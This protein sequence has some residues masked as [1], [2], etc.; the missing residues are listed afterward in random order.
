MDGSPLCHLVGQAGSA[1]CRCRQGPHH[2]GA[3]AQGDKLRKMARHLQALL[4]DRARAHRRG[5]GRAPRPVGDVRDLKGSLWDASSLNQPL[6]SD[7][8]AT[9]IGELIEDERASRLRARSL[10]RWRWT[11]SQMPSRGCPSAIVTFSSSATAWGDEEAATLAQQ[12]AR[13]LP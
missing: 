13:D 4:R 7:A 8:D 1:A 3:R 12:K 6:S 9:E 5:R 11:G 2:K 10:G